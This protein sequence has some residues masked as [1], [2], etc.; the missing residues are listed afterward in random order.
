[1]SP[2]VTPY[3]LKMHP[4]LSLDEIIRPLA[5]EIVASGAKATAVSLACCSKSFEGAVLDVLW[6]TQ[7]RLTPLLKCLPQEVWGEE[8]EKFVSRVM[9][10]V[11]FVLT[12]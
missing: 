3:G 8:N 7:D 6:E 2:L 11:P 10:N 1:M 9:F 5:C 12:G 4:C